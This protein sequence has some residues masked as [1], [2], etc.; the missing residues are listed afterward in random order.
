MLLWWQSWGVVGEN[1]PLLRK[2]PWHHAGEDEKNRR[3]PSRTM[4]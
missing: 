4:P 3:L 2:N 1:I